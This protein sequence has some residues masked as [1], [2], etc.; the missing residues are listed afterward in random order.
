[1]KNIAVIGLG[2]IAT[3]HRR[4]IKL[5]FPETKLIV[6][7]ASG[8]MPTETVSDSDYIA[9]SID[10]IVELGVQFAIIAS[11]APFHA[12]HAIPLIKGGIP[13]L[14]EKPVAVTQSDAQALINAENEYQTPVAV[15]YCL[16]YLPSAQKVKQ[17]LQEGILGTLYNVFIEIGQYLPDWRPTKDYRETVSAKA[18]LGGGVLLELSHELDYAQ[19][20]LG[21]LIPRHVILRSSEELG[22]DVEDNADLLMTTEKGTVVNIHLDFL[23]RQAHRKCRFIGSEG[24]IEWDLIQNEVVLITA[25]EREV[26]YSAPEWDK[27]QMYLEMVTD[28]IRK[29]NG[30]P[31]QSITLQE[32]EKTIGLI[33]K[34]KE[35]KMET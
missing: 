9:K 21:S 20:I 4:N 15:G 16:R 23:Q 29:I 11:P 14:I 6:M 1:M 31:N 18:E 26:I 27:N 24:C 33:V 8:R 30:Q 25:K 28:F 5:L 34:M 3:R 7:S 12:Q 2:N 35:F 17:I 32:A 13:V 19:W 22:L 10:E